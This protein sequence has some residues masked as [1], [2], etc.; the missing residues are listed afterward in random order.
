MSGDSSMDI[1]TLLCVK[2]M[3]RSAWRCDDLEGWDVGMGGR[4]MREGVYVYIWLIHFIVQQRPTQHCKT[5]LPPAK[6]KEEQM[7]G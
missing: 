5:T 4:S 7:K 6:K 1:Y 2:Q 3:G